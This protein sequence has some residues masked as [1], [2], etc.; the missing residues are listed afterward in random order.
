MWGFGVL[1]RSWIPS[2]SDEAEV[3]NPL[4]VPQKLLALD[5]L[6]GAGEAGPGWK[7]I[8]GQQGA[9]LSSAVMM[10]DSN[11]VDCTQKKTREI[12]QEK[13]KIADVSLLQKPTTVILPNARR[14]RRLQGRP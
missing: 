4:I 2:L 10:L 12:F 9:N 6:S 8:Y 14:S 5:L 1:F 13:A 11:G 3:F 7:A